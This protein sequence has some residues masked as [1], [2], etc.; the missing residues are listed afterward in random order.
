MAL[1]S[2]FKHEL[3]LRE[4]GQSTYELIQQLRTI[5]DREERTKRAQQ[6]V[7]LIFRLNASLRDQPDS[8]QKVWNHIF[9]MTDGE[10]DVDAPFELHKL[11]ILAKEP[12]RV[13][14]PTKAPKLK[15]YGASV[16]TMIAKALT[17][18][19]PTE[20]EQATIAIGRT[21]KFLYRS[22]SKENAK[23]I[24]ILKHLKE[25]SGG[26]LELDPAKVDAEGLFEFSTA[27]APAAPSGGRA[28]FVVPQ[29]RADR[30][31]RGDRDR[32]DR[33]MRR[34]G[35]NNRRDKQRR[36]GKKSRQEPQQPPQ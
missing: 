19:D 17:L 28:A 8:Q 21:M 10:L 35:N 22:Y 3:L 25:L 11:D 20:C 2:P 6:I 4:Y 34:G 33:E 32:G 27:P 31:E 16:D 1:P 24:T 12:Q 36:G 18:E 29:P 23:D 30:A 15:P 26:K 13:A 14:Y 9:E 5:D 7:Q